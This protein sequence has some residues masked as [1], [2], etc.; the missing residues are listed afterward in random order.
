VKNNVAVTHISDSY[1]HHIMSRSLVKNL[2]KAN[3]S[4]S[5]VHFF[6]TSRSLVHYIRTH[7]PH[8]EA[9]SSNRS[10]KMS[11]VVDTRD[12]LSL[13]THAVDFPYISLATSETCYMNFFSEMNIKLRIATKAKGIYEL[14]YLTLKTVI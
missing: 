13:I 11:H 7:S 4:R 3:L 1:I 10:L 14:L 12:P 5:N 6:K 8:P 2:S 9:V